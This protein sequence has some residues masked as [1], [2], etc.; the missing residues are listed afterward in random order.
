VDKDFDTWN[1]LKKNINSKQPSA[2]CN[3]REIWWASIGLNIGS[4][5]DGKNE[6]FERPVLIIKVFSKDMVRIIPLTS[7]LRDDYNHVLVECEGR[8]NSVILSQMKTV[9]SYRFTRK[10]GKLRI[11][12][13]SNVIR[14]LKQN[15]L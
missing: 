10:F 5:E 13:F 11:D 6:L 15:L 8:I 4:E 7:A 1:K 9:S 2:F 3:V 12:D 14:R